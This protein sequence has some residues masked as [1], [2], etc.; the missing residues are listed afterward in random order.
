[1]TIIKLDKNTWN[2]TT[3]FKLFV[4]ARDIWYIIV[5]KRN[6]LKINYRKKYN[7]RDSLTSMY[8]II[9]KKMWSRS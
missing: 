9:T 8:E 4:L 5:C 7:E 3:L 6:F 1:M 2:H